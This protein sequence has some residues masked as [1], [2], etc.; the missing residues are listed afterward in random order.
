[1]S[2]A[3][4]ILPWWSSIYLPRGRRIDSLRSV[5]WAA[6]AHQYCSLMLPPWMLSAVRSRIDS[7]SAG[8]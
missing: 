2:A 5:F 1:M 8:E 3:D 7:Q 6:V 4:S